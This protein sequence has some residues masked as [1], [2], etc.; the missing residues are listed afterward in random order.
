MNLNKF[1][2]QKGMSIAEAL[3]AVSCFYNVM[4]ASY[5][6]YNNFQEHLSD[7]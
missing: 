3:I 5:T 1:I 4:G 2:N 6:I 7:K